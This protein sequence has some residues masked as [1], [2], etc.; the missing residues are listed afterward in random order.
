MV[1]GVIILVALFVLVRFIVWRY[2]DT[3]AVPNIAGAAIVLAFVF[4]SLA[5]PFSLPATGIAG[6]A[7]AVGE[8]SPAPEMVTN[9]H[10][11]TAGCLATA[12]AFKIGFAGYFDALARNELGGPVVAKG[13][14]IPGDAQYVASGWGVNHDQKQL[15]RAVC[16]LVDGKIAPNVTSIYG[17]IRPDVA[18]SL[19]APLLAQAGFKIIIPPNS[20]KNG[21]HH[22]A[23]A[24]RSQD[25]TF[26]LADNSWD[27]VVR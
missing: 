2:A 20:I 15:A 16:L 11:V 13:S 19:H 14:S 24:I 7:T 6:T 21:R 26:S 22:L 17:I 8:T 3:T 9:V 23:V 4:G 25:D 18:A 27:V 12:P 5:R 10:D 1:L